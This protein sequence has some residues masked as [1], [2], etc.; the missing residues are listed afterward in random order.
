M[1]LDLLKKFAY[2]TC[3]FSYRRIQSEEFQ[4]FEKLINTRAESVRIE[5]V[6]KMINEEMKLLTSN[7]LRSKGEYYSENVQLIENNIIEYLQKLMKEE[8][9]K[10]EKCDFPKKDERESTSDKSSKNIPV[11]DLNYKNKSPKGNSNKLNNIANRNNFPKSSLIST[12][13]PF[14][15][16]KMKFLY[17]PNSN[18]FTKSPNSV[19][20]PSLGSE[21]KYSSQICTV[22]TRASNR[23]RPLQSVIN[24]ASSFVSI[25]LSSRIINSDIFKHR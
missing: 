15:N 12:V 19:K 22:K 4:I 9:E 21:N 6:Y 7:N 20:E 25:Y 11:L 2:I 18:K 3:D 24:I 8:N 17:L 14:T 10:T 13:M 1:N 5:D 23:G 16:S